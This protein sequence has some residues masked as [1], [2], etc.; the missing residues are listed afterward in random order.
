MD[1]ETLQIPLWRQMK[2]FQSWDFDFLAA[3]KP[4]EQG[5][6]ELEGNPRTVGEFFQNR[7]FQAARRAQR[8]AQNDSLTPFDGG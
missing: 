8:I 3:R 5:Y 4:P 6:P 7:D 1:V 2:K